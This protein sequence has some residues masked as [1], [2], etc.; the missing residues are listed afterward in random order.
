[1]KTLEAQG[2]SALAVFSAL[3][4]ISANFRPPLRGGTDFALGTGVRNSDPTWPE[5]RQRYQSW[6]SRQI[7]AETWLLQ[8]PGCSGAAP[9]GS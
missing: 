4:S 5:K 7:A 1:M 3:T 8:S 6:C 9:G 2:F